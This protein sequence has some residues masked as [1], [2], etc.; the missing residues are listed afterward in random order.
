MDIQAKDHV[1]LGNIR[2]TIVSKLT[3]EEAN[4]TIASIVG[5][6]DQRIRNSG[7][8]V[9]IFEEGI[10]AKLT[11]IDFSSQNGGGR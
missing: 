4:Q 11:D 10:V 2:L 7:E 6:I 3:P 9:Q 1:D 5:G 8:G